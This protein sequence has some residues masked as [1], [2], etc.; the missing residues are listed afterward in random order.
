MNSTSI[1]QTVQRYRTLRTHRIYAL[2]IVI[3]MPHSACNCRCVMCDIWK[4]NHHLKQL[5]E[6]DV[7][8]LLVALKK[9]GSQQVVMSGGEALLHGNFFRLCELLRKEGISISL[10]STGIALKKN[11]EQIARLVQDVVVSVDGD[12]EVHDL[13]RN[14]PGAFNKLKQGVDA[15]REWDEEFP[16]S[17]RTVI[18]RMNFRNWP[19]IIEAGKKLGLDRMSFL[20]A[21]VSSHAFNREVLWTESRQHELLPEEQELDELKGVLEKI[22]SECSEDFSSGFIA[23]SPEKLWK[24]YEYYAAFYGRNPFPF[25]KCNAPWV[26]TVIEADGTVRPCFFHEA[27]GNI[28][29]TPLEAILNSEKAKS[30][31]KNLDMGTDP[32]C[33]RCVCSLHLPPRM[34][35]KNPS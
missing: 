17:S 22:I 13:I 23:E 34:N 26:S 28:H 30:F 10:L 7:E 6:Q 27:I 3:L 12:E 31:R 5:S 15:I 32:T 21:D 29:Q 11:A 1:Y 16:L 18:H 8:K 19:G 14:I 2:P 9:F 25:K 24:I 35:L 20:P 4:G 33:Q